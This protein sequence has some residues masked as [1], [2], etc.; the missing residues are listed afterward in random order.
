LIFTG[1]VSDA[2]SSEVMAE[3][4]RAGFF[5]EFERIFRMALH[6]GAANVPLRGKSPET[7]F[8]NRSHQKRF[9]QSCHRGYDKAQKHTVEV[10]GR[11][12]ALTAISADEKDHWQLL[13]RKI[14]D[15][16]TVALF[17]AES[18]VI[19]RLS[20]HRRP[21]KI[22]FE[23]LRQTLESATALNSKSRLTFA[24]VADLTTFVH[25]CD[26]IQIDFRR[27]QR[28]VSMIE[29]KSGKVNEL[30]LKQLESYTPS[31]E[32]I[33][34]ISADPLVAE[35]KYRPQAERILRQKLRLRQIQEVLATDAGTDI[36]TNHPIRLSSEEVRGAVYDKMLNDL[37]NRA[38]DE[39]AAAGVVNYCVHIGVGH[40]DQF[41]RASRRALS[42][43]RFGI[44]TCL[45][46]PPEGLVNVVAE[47]KAA[48][49]E[50]ELF[51]TSELLSSNL[52][53][54]NSRPFTVWGI[55][56]TNLMSF[57]KSEFVV[58]SAFD[59]SAF[60]WLARRCGLNM[61]LSTR[62]IATQQAQKIGSVNVPT[63][64]NRALYWNAGPAQIFVSSGFI[65]RL[66]ND[67]TNPLPFLEHDARE[68][69]L[70]A[71]E[72]ESPGSDAK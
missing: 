52:A 63:W 30:L 48:I 67:L 13:L 2:S 39:G 1:Y 12:S 29:L 72:H 36:A 41:E 31:R 22:S 49:P 50:H 45:E 61:R 68:Q 7:A 15:G 62:K 44:R 11:I 9:L 55:E 26:I 10:M 42:A 16:V 69:F 19:R 64:G 25:V 8:L 71:Y 59:V 43:L 35:S 21:P 46:K 47:M 20:F 34:T 17:R 40:S 56:P 54:M 14:I 33:A 38:R 60:V 58:L 3:M 5:E 57:V 53:A 32:S 37:L 23:T 65:S 18:H 6:S 27:D 70:E 51:K 4:N 66:I 24:L 28:R